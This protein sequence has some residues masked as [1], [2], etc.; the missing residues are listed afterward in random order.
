VCWYGLVGR[1]ELKAVELSESKPNVGVELLVEGFDL[2][3]EP[4]HVPLEVILLKVK[5]PQDFR[6]AQIYQNNSTTFFLKTQIKN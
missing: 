2:T 6:I 4:Q 1:Y 5:V 3:P